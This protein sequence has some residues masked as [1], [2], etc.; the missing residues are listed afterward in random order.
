MTEKTIIYGIAPLGL[1]FI[2]ESR[3][4]ELAESNQALLSA[5]T[6][7]EF[8]QRVSEDLYAFYLVNS[9]FYQ[10]S[11]NPFP[12]EIED[13][14]LPGETPFTPN[15]VVLVDEL[16]AHPEIEMS[17]WMPVEILQKFSRKIPYYGKDMNVP[18]GD[19][20][21]LDEEKIGEIAAALEELGFTCRRD[22]KL[23]IAATT[24]DFDPNEY[25]EVEEGE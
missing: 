18:D 19:V 17:A 25:P 14:D 2:P 23:L 16:P 4:K 22:D 5:K 3:A 6:W 12:H 9:S 11:A 10:G 21:V 7:G 15:D 13:Y 20:L 8:K 1:L 24:L